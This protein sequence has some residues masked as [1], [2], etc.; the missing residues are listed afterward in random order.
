LNYVVGRYLALRGQWDEAVPFLQFA[1]S[2]PY[3]R[4]TDTRTL[5]CAALRDRGLTPDPER[6]LPS[7]NA[8]AKPDAAAKSDAAKPVAK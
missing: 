1:A 3:L 4:F 6:K 8:A 7:P 2:D 5:A